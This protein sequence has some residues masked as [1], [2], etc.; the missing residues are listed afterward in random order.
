M[1]SNIEKVNS[2]TRLLDNSLSAMK[3]YN[4]TTTTIHQAITNYLIL[5]SPVKNARKNTIKHSVSWSQNAKQYKISART[6]YSHISRNFTGWILRLS[7]PNHPQ[8][9]W[10]HSWFIV[11]VGVKLATLPVILCM[12]FEILDSKGF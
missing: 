6:W 7:T 10:E 1:I 9:S 11:S 5:S 2:L 12:R 8:Q 4:C 3:Y